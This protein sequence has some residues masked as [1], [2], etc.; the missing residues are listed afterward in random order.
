MSVL[1]CWARHRGRRALYTGPSDVLI[2]TLVVLFSQFLSSYVA[3][4]YLSVQVLFGAGGNI[5]V[6]VV[7]AT[8]AL[9]ALRHKESLTEIAVGLLWA[10]VIGTGVSH[11]VSADANLYDVWTYATHSIL[12]FLAPCFVY[13]ICR[14]GFWRGSVAAVTLVLPGAVYI[15]EWA[16]MDFL[17]RNSEVA[18]TAGQPVYPDTEMIYAQQPALI[19]AETEGLR[20]SDPSKVELFA[21]LGAGYADQRVFRREVEA[22]GYVLE[23]SFDARDRVVRLIN[24]RD[25]AYRRPLMN[26]VNLE[27]ALDTVGKAMGD[28]DLLLL[29]LT[30][31]GSAERFSLRFSGVISRDLTPQDIN[32]SLDKAGINSAILIVSACYS[33]SFVETLARPN[34]LVLTAS[35]ADRNSFGCSDE[36]E[37]TD[38]GRAFFTQGWVET[39][40]PRRAAVVAQ[41]LVSLWESE[42]GLTPSLPQISEG[43]E[44][45]SVLDAWLDDLNVEMPPNAA[46]QAHAL[47]RPGAALFGHLLPDGG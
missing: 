11:L 5:V 43:G 12:P 31:H 41:D 4:G 35:A 29:F 10:M 27:A 7:A 2:A 9:V 30:S 20:V 38:W 3:F 14:V 37:W 40:D 32:A 42:R 46:F 16:M 23:Q 33:G 24:E 39:A 17:S 34:R 15:G 28:E 1:F 8:L 21:V 45:G 18:E 26:R 6:Y 13:L 25:D 36:N 19:E 22:V 47:L 44:I